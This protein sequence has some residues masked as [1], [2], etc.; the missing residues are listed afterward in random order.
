MTFLFILYYLFD[1]GSCGAARRS[2]FASDLACAYGCSGFFFS[3]WAL[4]WF[5]ILRSS[6]RFGWR[7]RGTDWR[8][9]GRGWRRRADMGRRAGGRLGQVGLVTAGLELAGG[10]MDGL[11]RLGR[12]A[13][14]R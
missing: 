5:R 11:P 10:D 9:L 1:T 2:P 3:H 12:A 6:G 7:G 13:V 4:V 8:R 14:A